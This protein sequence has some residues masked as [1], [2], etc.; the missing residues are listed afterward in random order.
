MSPVSVSGPEAPCTTASATVSSTPA[1]LGRSRSGVTSYRVRWSVAIRAWIHLRAALLASA[2][3]SSTTRTPLPIRTGTGVPSTRSW[4]PPSSPSTGWLKMSS[5]FWRRSTHRQPARGVTWSIRGRAVSKPNSKSLPSTEPS[6]AFSPAGTLTR[7][8]VARGRGCSGAN[9]SVEEPSQ[10]HSPATFGSMKAAGGS[11]RS[12]S[13]V[14]MGATGRSKVM[15][16]R[17]AP[18]VGP[19]G[20]AAATSSFP[21]TPPAAAA[22]FGA[23]GTGSRSDRAAGLRAPR[24]ASAI[25]TATQARATITTIHFVLLVI[26]LSG[27]VAAATRTDCAA[28]T[29]LARGPATGEPNRRRLEISGMWD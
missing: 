22:S 10:R 8:A 4:T 17:A 26:S 16:G 23:L 29:T 28:P 7:K 24:P 9:S 6:S 27:A 18:S 19:L 13:T 25:A 14:A 20:W 11:W 3:S 1:P 21:G 12:S 2:S 5:N 15:V